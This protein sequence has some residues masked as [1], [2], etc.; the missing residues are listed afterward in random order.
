M[1]AH[2]SL[3]SVRACVFDAYG[4]VMNLGDLSTEFAAALGD[5][6]APLMDLWRRKQLE[7][8]WLRTLMGQHADFWTVTS[9][10]LD[11]A[12]SSFGL[13]DPALRARM[14]QAWMAPCPYPEVPAMLDRLRAAELKTAILSNGSVTMLTAGIGAAGLTDRLDAVLSVES[15]GRFKPHPSV[16]ALAVERF[17]CTPAEICFVSGNG[18]DVAGAASF[19]FKVVWINR[20]GVPQE[21]LPCGPDVVLA[22]LDNL[23]DILGA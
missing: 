1:T 15:V 21:R 22:S 10:A 3:A 5:K 4:T 11:Y 2:P 7:Y 19:G 23:A 6:T 17:G 18:W 13:D 12:L 16:Y 9:D 20:A 14:M 8:S